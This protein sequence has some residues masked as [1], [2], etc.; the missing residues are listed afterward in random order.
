MMDVFTMVPYCNLIRNGRFSFEKNFRSESN[1]IHGIGWMR[2]W[3]V[4]EKEYNRL[5]L[6]YRHDGVDWP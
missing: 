5:R 4:E 2:E 3:L 1:S 6:S